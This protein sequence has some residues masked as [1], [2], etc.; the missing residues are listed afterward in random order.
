M[1]LEANL[2]D[3]VQMKVALAEQARTGLKFGSTLVELKFIDENVLAAFLSRQIDIPCISLLHV[4][5]PR[6]ITR[7][8]SPDVAHRCHAIP[9]RIHN[10]QLEVAM[11]D[12]TD[13]DL[14]RIL[15]GE[16]GMTVSPLVAPQ[17]SIEKMLDKLY[18]IDDD[19]T[20]SAEPDASIHEVTDPMF[21]DLIEEI[22]SGDFDSRLEHIEEKLEQVWTI[23]E[24]ILRHIEQERVSAH[25]HDRE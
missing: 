11:A 2:I 7:T 6:K 5:I 1:L 10:E 8:L 22:E 12:P 9:V 4:E 20:L 14:L 25:L 24:K 13:I 18:P 15:E 17:S 16:A 3:E 23:L 19:S 21:R